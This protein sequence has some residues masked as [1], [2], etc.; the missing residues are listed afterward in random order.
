MGNRYGSCSCCSSCNPLLPLFIKPSDASVPYDYYH[1][2][3]DNWSYGS[4]INFYYLSG[5]QNDIGLYFYNTIKPYISPYEEKYYANGYGGLLYS[6]NSE[7]KIIS[8]Q[9]I[10]S[11]SLSFGHHAKFYI[12]LESIR[13]SQKL[14]LLF[15]YKSEEDYY[16]LEISNFAESEI[17]IF[18]N[19]LSGG[20]EPRR[21]VLK[22]VKANVSIKHLNNVI[23]SDNLIIYERYERTYFHGTFYTYTGGDYKN[24]YFYLGLTTYVDGEGNSN[25]IGYLFDELKDFSLGNTFR[26]SLKASLP[27]NNKVDYSRIGFTCSSGCYIKENSY[28]Y[29]SNSDPCYY[30]GNQN[31]NSFISGNCYQYAP[32]LLGF[33][34]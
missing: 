30:N 11:Q 3:N 20:E 33:E 6:S 26:F 17:L 21:T 13:S 25:V 4:G 2:R 22:Q 1:Y 14:G 9:S 27:E 24:I 12:D 34:C 19:T 8:R 16:I 29:V 32:L 28:S 5:H 10:N 23:A 31:V 18:E 15:N 7:E